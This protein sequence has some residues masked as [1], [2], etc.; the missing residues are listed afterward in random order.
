MNIQVLKEIVNKRGQIKQKVVRL[1]NKSA[2]VGLKFNTVNELYTELLLKY[3]AEDFV[4][5]GKALD[6]NYV[7]LKNKFY[8]GKDLKHADE[9]YYSSLPTEIKTKLQGVYYS[10][11][12]IIST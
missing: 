6:G 3:K 12:I 5:I 11:D 4:I 1:T 7:T 10:I 9:E 8:T 2:K